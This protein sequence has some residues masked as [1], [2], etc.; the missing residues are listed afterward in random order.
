MSEDKTATSRGRKPEKLLGKFQREP[1]AV[2]VRWGVF[3]FGGGDAEKVNRK[4][5]VLIFSGTFKK[6]KIV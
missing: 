5:K 2:A 6:N 3:F 1:P 4:N